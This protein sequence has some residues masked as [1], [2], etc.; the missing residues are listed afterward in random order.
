MSIDTIWEVGSIR[1]ISADATE[2]GGLLNLIGISE[3]Q[4][5]VKSGITSADD[6]HPW[7]F[8]TLEQP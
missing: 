8:L 6:Y 7:A 2:I 5:R 4:L 1:R 3:F